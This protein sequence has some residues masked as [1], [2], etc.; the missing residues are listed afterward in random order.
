MT[1]GE[2]KKIADEFCKKVRENARK[3]GK[4]IYGR[5]Y[6]KILEKGAYKV[7]LYDSGFDFWKDN[8]KDIE[9]LKNNAICFEK[10]DV[11]YGWND[12]NV[13]IK[14]A[15]IRSFVFFIELN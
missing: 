13:R 7:K 14:H 6:T 5:R 12:Q 9:E 2:A 1:K 3:N 4:N 8:K 10:D 15:T 11:N